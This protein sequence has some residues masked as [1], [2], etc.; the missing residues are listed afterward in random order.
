M[1]MKSRLL[2]PAGV[3]AAALIGTACV[4]PPTPPGGGG[5]T[6]PAPTNPPP[7]G[8]TSCAPASSAAAGPDGADPIASWGVDG[9]A[10]A[11]V[12]I[13]NV[14]YVGGTFNNAV[15]PTGVTA[16]RA[17]LAA[18]CLADGNLL[19]SFSA[20]FGGGP[21]NALATDGASLFVGGNFTTL[22]GAASNR[23][24]KLNAGTGVRDTSFSPD[25]IP[26]PRATPPA[27]PPEG[28]LD[29]AF[30]GST[31]VLYA[32]GDF[33]KIGTGG[34]LMQSTKVDNAAGFNANGSLTAFR[35]GTDK[36]VESIAV[37]PDGSTVF[38][39]GNFTTVHGVNRGQMARVT[40]TAADAAG[41]Q[42]PNYGIGAKVLDI[43]AT[44]SNDV[45]AAVGGA[46][47]GGTG[48]RRLVSFSGATQGL[49]D[50]NPQGD[51]QAV[52]LIG[53]TAYFG[54]QRGYGANNGPNLVGVPTSGGAVTF[55]A[56]AAIAAPTVQGVMDLAVSQGGA[57]LVA[58]G[59]FTSVGTT[60]SL[61]G[62]A[63]FA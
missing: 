1:R 29:L 12:V 24:V 4:P 7:V 10:K 32:G 63:I 28:V 26:A 18:F 19:S 14:V 11:T 59:D 39:G 49:N 40:A 31:G 53:G 9:S 6:T 43:A 20:N 23:L 22:N 3:A 35:G 55:S 2:L 5:P 52:E 61:H 17:N 34:G 16:P 58:V 13:G 42:S 57:R 25:P 44:S 51:V 38:L 27:N 45:V 48:G 21:V 47:G 37:S 41:V 50:V 15:S 36:L 8:T 46:L 62:L 56:T 60:G 30:S 33:G 54:M